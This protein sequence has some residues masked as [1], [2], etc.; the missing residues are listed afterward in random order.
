MNRDALPMRGPSNAFAGPF[1]GHA[2]THWL[3]DYAQMIEWDMRSLRLVL[4]TAII[5]QVMLG[6]GLAIGFGFLVGETTTAEATFLATG[7][8]VVSMLTVGLVLV[9]QV[10]AQRKHEGTY[11]Y[12]W[13]LPVKRTASVAGSLTVNTLIALPGAVIALLVS[14][15][16]YDLSLSVGPLVVPAAIL[17]L[18]T[19]ASIGYALAHGIRNPMITGIATNVLVFFVLLYSPINFPPERLPGWLA[20]LHQGLPFQHAANVMRAGLTSGVAN[21]VG[22]SFAILAAWAVAAWVLTAWVIGRRP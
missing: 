2:L 22:R 1:H 6:A 21:D 13:S 20:T 15:W 4:P 3:R 12:V 9:P 18:V 10:I 14:S 11:D 16:R 19:T 7:V 5:L 17:T 8:T